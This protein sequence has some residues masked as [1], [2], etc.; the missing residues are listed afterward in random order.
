MNVKE[1]NSLPL[2]VFFEAPEKWE[3]QEI[4]LK[5]FLYQKEGQTLLA[6]EPNIP[7]CCLK[8]KPSLLLDGDF[9]DLASRAVLVQGQMMKGSS[10]WTMRAAK[11]VEE[12][13]N[14]EE[15]W[16]LLGLM[17]LLVCAFGKY[18]KTLKIYL[19]DRFG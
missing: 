1:K 3:G 17:F 13:S 5:G 7:S 6:L 2:S 9:P 4:A 11:Q 10:G 15:T 16:A 19:K 14:T 8:K 18:W 12:K